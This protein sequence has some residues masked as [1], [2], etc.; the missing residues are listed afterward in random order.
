MMELLQKYV[1]EDGFIGIKN[2]DRWP[3]DSV[4]VEFPSSTTSA[5]LAKE[6]TTMSESSIH[7]I[8]VRRLQHHLL[9]C[10]WREDWLE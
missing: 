7:A 10:D 8:L 4:V 1:K 3:F 9:Q 6:L 5:N 2:L